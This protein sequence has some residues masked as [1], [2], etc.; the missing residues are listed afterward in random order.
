MFRSVVVGLLAIGYVPGVAS[1]GVVSIPSPG[2]TADIGARIR[3]G[4][5]GFEASVYDS[6]PFG[7]APTLNPVGAPVWQ[8]GQAYNFQLT[9]SAATGAIGLSIDFNN[10]G[11]FGAGETISQNAFAA[12]GFANYTGV[13]FGYLEINGNE[14]G[15]AARSQLT[16]LVLN[17]TPFPD[18]VPNGGFVQAFFTDSPSGLLTNLT[19]TGQI[20]F[21]TAGTAGERPAYN[22]IFGNAGVPTVIPEPATLALVGAAFAAAFAARR[23]RSAA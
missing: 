14:S 15:S 4:G 22:F 11:T 3:W 23:R 12:P 9:Y 20:T 18:V 8:V 13:G 17:G 2:G 5:T 19:L 6:N 1:A 10:G 7:Q 21:L 16:N